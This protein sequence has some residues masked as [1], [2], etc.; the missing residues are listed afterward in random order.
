LVDDETLFTFYDQRIPQDVIS[1]RHFDKWWKIAQKNSPD[2]LSFEKS[3]LIKE[4]A[5]RVSALDYPNYWHQDNL[6]LRLT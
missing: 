4:D 6:K 2:L 5:K 1:T 3:M